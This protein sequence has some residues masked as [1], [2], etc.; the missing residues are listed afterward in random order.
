M[1]YNAVYLIVNHLL[2]RFLYKQFPVHNKAGESIQPAWMGSQAG[3]IQGV[4]G[5]LVVSHLDVQFDIIRVTV[6]L[7][8]YYESGARTQSLNNTRHAL[9]NG[10]K[11][12]VSVGSTDARRTAGQGVWWPSQKSSAADVVVK[13]AE[14]RHRKGDRAFSG[15]VNIK[16]SN[17][18]RAHGRPSWVHGDPAACSMV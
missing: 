13:G 6:Q 12:S 14:R 5:V 1:S 7:R 4:V 10:A 11:R 18:E 16:A 3:S 15:S 2:Y 17:A 9:A 8:A